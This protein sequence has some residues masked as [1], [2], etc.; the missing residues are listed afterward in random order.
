MDAWFFS[1]QWYLNPTRCFASV[2]RFSFRNCIIPVP[3]ASA[4][5]LNSLHA[6]LQ[7]EYGPRPS[8]TWDL[9]LEWWKP[10]TLFLFRNPIVRIVSIWRCNPI[11]GSFWLSTRC[12]VSSCRK[13]N[14]NDTMK[15]IPLSIF[16][17]SA[18][19]FPNG[20]NNIS[21]AKGIE[22]VQ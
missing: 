15:C 12:S 5:Y 7:S 16:L 21:F 8:N 14:A 18:L 20:S 17:D 19:R 1:N 3:T 2:L 13:Q 6:S 9:R 11:Y 10:R 4:I 22:K